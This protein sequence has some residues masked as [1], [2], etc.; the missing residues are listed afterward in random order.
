MQREMELKFAATEDTALPEVVSTGAAVT[1]QLEA[2]Y[3]DTQ[4]LT[5]FREKITLRRRVGGKDDGWHIKFPGKQSRLEAHFPLSDDLPDQVYDRLSYLLLGRTLIPV[6][7]VRNTREETQ[8]GD[9]EFCDDHV[10]TTCLLSGEERQWREWEIEA[11]PTLS[12]K[13]AHKALAALSDVIL[14][15]G[16]QPADS[17]SKL[18]AALGASA[19]A[20]RPASTIG[21]LREKLIAADYLV[22]TDPASGIA[23]LYGACCSLTLLVPD[24]EDIAG[25]ARQ[26]ADLTLKAMQSEDCAT[27]S[28][29]LEAP[30]AFVSSCEKTAARHIRRVRAALDHPQYHAF[31]QAIDTAADTPCDV[32][33]RARQLAE[34]LRKIKL[35]PSPTAEDINRLEELCVAVISAQPH[36][37]RPDATKKERKQAKEHRRSHTALEPLMGEL[38]DFQRITA[39]AKVMRDKAAFLPSLDAFALGA[40]YGE[41]M[42]L[43][44]KKEK[45]LLKAH[46]RAVKRIKQAQD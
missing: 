28:A 9:I 5:L 24:N 40:S 32:S 13:Q 14:A 19:P 4:D 39:T 46:R 1:H 21:I 37:P 34:E 23:R 6:A 27:L 20:P 2:T 42:R 11:D 43:H 12:D 36:A 7:V 10:S 25:G 33:D 38:L 22:R 30:A 16:A 8:L 15:T 26:L 17:P 44:H 18:A 35:G 31:R 45:G 29:S 41:L 3:Y